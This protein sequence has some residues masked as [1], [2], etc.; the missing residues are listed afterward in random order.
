MPLALALCCIIFLLT[1][2]APC[3]G[4]VPNSNLIGKASR[5]TAEQALSPSPSSSLIPGFSTVH[6]FQLLNPDGRMPP[7]VCWNDAIPLDLI[8]D[9]KM[10][11]LSLRNSG[12][13]AKAGVAGAKQAHDIRRDVHQVWLQSPGSRTLLPMVGNMDARKQFLRL[14]EMLRVDLE[15]RGGA[16]RW[17]SLCPE[18][19]ELSYLLYNPGSFYGKHVDTIADNVT[20]ERRRD[21][22]RSVS[23]IIFLGDDESDRPWTSNDGGA[24]RI[25][26]SEYASMTG[27]PVYVDEKDNVHSDILPTPGTIVL[28]D[29]EKVLHEVLMTNRNRICSVGWF[30]SEIA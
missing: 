20:D 30:G 5:T 1:G 14:I 3:Q 21:F 8:H 6:N 23:M 7:L 2:A 10:D 11:A 15:E 17:S 24:V 19:V 9:V 29:S 13:G 26:G 22:K 16:G 4:Y 18:F 25:Y 28:F 27:S 12:F